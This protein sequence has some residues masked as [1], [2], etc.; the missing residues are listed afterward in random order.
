MREKEFDI[1]NNILHFMHNDS[2]YL[3]DLDQLEVM[4]IH[5]DS[6]VFVEN[7]KVKTVSSS[8]FDLRLLTYAL[9]DN[10][11]YMVCGRGNIVNLGLV[12]SVHIVRL[13]DERGL[14]DKYNVM[15]I[16][17]NRTKKEITLNSWRE[18]ERLYHQIDDKL[19]DIKSNVKI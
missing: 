4:F 10:P 11:N 7:G 12:Q 13:N 8:C 19:C 16:F 6:V 9:L 2:D 5:L 14:L 15:L 1:N 17:N 3:I 18:A